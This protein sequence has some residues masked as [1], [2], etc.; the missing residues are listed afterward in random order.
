MKKMLGEGKRESIFYNRDFML[1][2]L[3]GLVSR[4]GSSIHYVAM[5]WLVLELTGRGSSAGLLLL[6][7][8]LPGVLLG[9][10]AGVMVDRWNR[11]FIIVGMDVVRGL[12]VC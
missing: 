4:I 5:I 3:G 11:K 7:A 1:L 12:V 6:L 8:T 2:F 10:L 9:P